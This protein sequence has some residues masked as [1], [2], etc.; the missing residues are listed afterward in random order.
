MIIFLDVPRMKEHEIVVALKINKILQKEDTIIK[1]SKILQ[2]KLTIK[3]VVAFYSL[4]KCYN[5]ATISESSL[6]IYNVVFQW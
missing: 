3:N 5:L 2:D 1:I 6:L 4:A